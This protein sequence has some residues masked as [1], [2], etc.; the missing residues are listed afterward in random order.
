MSDVSS[1]DRG[2]SPWVHVSLG[3]ILCLVA[4]NLF[5][6]VQQG[7]YRYDRYGNLVVSLLLLFHHVAFRYTK[8]GWQSKVMKVAAVAWVAFGLV[9]ILWLWVAGRVA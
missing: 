2:V 9:Y 6:L 4:A 3:L 5:L 1:T 8:T 7:D